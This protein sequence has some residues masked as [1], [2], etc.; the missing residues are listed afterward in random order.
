M[1]EKRPAGSKKSAGKCKRKLQLLPSGQSL[2]VNESSSFC[3]WDQ[4]KGWS[5]RLLRAKTLLNLKNTGALG[6][7]LSMQI[8]HD[9]LEFAVILERIQPWVTGSQHRIG[10]AAVG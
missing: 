9:S 10:K 6:F 8:G 1:P 7:I 4:S 3:P 5:L 2:S